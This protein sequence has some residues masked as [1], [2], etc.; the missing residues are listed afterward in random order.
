MEFAVDH[1]V[2]AI[3]QLERMR[4]IAIHMTVAVRNTA[5]T[6]K[7][8]NLVSR[9]RPERDEVP[10]HVSVLSKEISLMRLSGHNVWF[11]RNHVDMYAPS[12]VSRDFSF[13][14]G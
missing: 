12:N 8:H 6:K 3:N 7:K 1:L 9:L 14:C 5:I 4:T 10:E 2:L 13:A 11:T